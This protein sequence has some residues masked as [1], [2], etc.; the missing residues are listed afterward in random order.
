MPD[1]KPA[2]KEKLKDL[3]LSATR[4]ASILDELS[5][6][7]DDAYRDARST[8]LSETEATTR[9]LA[10][11]E[12]GD[13]LTRG[14][15]QDPQ[16]SSR[17]ETH[18]LGGENVALA[19]AG[20][21]QV[22]ARGLRASRTFTSVVVLSLALGIG[23]NT[24]LF[25]LI[26]TLLVRTL[27]VPQPEQLV[28]VRQVAMLGASSKTFGSFPPPVFDAV[29]SQST[30]VADVAGFRRLDR[31]AVKFYGTL[32]SQ[33]IV[34]EV[35]TGF[36][37]TLGVNA[38]LGRTPHTS[39]ATVAVLSHRL[40]TTRFDG[41]PSVLNRIAEVDGRPYTIIG[42]APKTFRGVAVENA[43]D[44][45]VSSSS[46]PKHLELIARLRPE[47]LPSQAEA[48]LRVTFAR[49]AE[50]RTGVIPWNDRMRIEAAPA[51]RGFSSLR[52]EYERSLMA[53][54]ALVSLVLLVTCAN[55]GNLLALRH[56]ARLRTFAV[57]MALG[58]SRAR[59]VRFCLAEAVLVSV[60]G[61][62]AA[63]AFAH[64]G[65]SMLLA[66][67]PL[68]TIPDGLS[69]QI[70]ARVLAFTAATSFIGILLFGLAPAWRATGFEP[71]A[72]LNSPGGDASRSSG[73]LSRA[74]MASQ[75]GLAV[76]LL[77]G[78][79]LFGQTLR[80]L[81]TID[82]GFRPDDLLQV[83]LD[84]AG[85][86]YRQ[87]QTGALYLHLLEKIGAIPGVVSVAGVRNPVM[88]NSRTRRMMPMRGQDY[89]VDRAWEGAEVSAS[90][91][92][93]MGL[94]TLLGRTFTQDDF[95]AGRRLVVVSESFARE[96]FPGEN[97]VGV[98]GGMNNDVEIIG[99]VRDARLAN[100]REQSAPMMYDMAPPEPDRVN[101]LVVRVSGPTAPVAAALRD[102]LRTIHPR[103]LVDVRTMRT[104]MD[105]SVARERLVAAASGFFGVLALLLASIGIYGVASQSVAQRTRDL[106]IRRALGA[107]SVPIVRESLRGVA[108]A[109]AAGL[110]VGSLGSVALLRAVGSLITDLLFGL[111]ATDAFSLGT[112]LVAMA[113][114]AV[115]AA[116]VPAHRAI[117]IDPLHVIRRE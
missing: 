35:S 80:N 47:I 76:I 29:R 79:S 95:A 57:R 34:D 28:F 23:A 52:R 114:T 12:G 89:G 93:T 4:E 33:R 73:L 63:L 58:A 49:L 62:V 108:G 88:Q 10:E 55:V 25:S 87:G 84:T 105:R 65:V 99:V 37:D 70:D 94:K 8:G 104:E 3:S 43:T 59:L 18:P 24:A 45:W 13:L 46:P 42:I 51:G 40:W 111:N 31:P 90:F 19:F 68:Q 77:V 30:V 26:D 69:L 53:L 67:L 56:A 74:L 103:L 85:A 109:L 98:R 6:H 38:I 1:W 2:I 113:A 5:Q 96:Y 107:P 81:A 39:D 60:M 17:V 50:E 20:D 86:G 72:A 11:L 102:A 97:P 7:L 117:T 66:M 78:A 71:S 112:A 22:A 44:L 82:V 75:V 48:A 101:G 36:F 54:G 21:L 61:A 110:M 115:A 16:T 116:A 92:E 64:G 14:L 32:D 27:A 41:S 83:T 91:F 15:A 100:L 9:A 106:G